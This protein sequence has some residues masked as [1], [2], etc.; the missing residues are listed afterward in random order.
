MSDEAR[1]SEIA[2]CQ[3]AEKAV[4][5]FNDAHKG[6][7]EAIKRIAKMLERGGWG[8]VVFES[9]L[10]YQSA[11]NIVPRDIPPVAHS[12]LEGDSIAVMV[13]NY[14]QLQELWKAAYDAV[15][16]MIKSSAPAPREAPAKL[17]DR[18]R[19]G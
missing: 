10:P 19:R 13:S 15:P 9:D 2:A 6:R 17:H 3:A 4:Q 12:D 8:S 5:D 18:P 1:F 16:T 14:R 7:A 11:S